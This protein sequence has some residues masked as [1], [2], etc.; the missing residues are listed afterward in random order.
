MELREKDERNEARELGRS[1]ILQ[2][3]KLYGHKNLLGKLISMSAL[4]S[5]LHQASARESHF[6][7]FPK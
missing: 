5:A 2:V 1:Q 7:Y 6:Y 4:E 3:F